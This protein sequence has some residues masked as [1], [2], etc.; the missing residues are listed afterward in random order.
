MVLLLKKLHR[1]W[2]FIAVLLVFI[3]FFPYLY[4]L[5]LEP[6][7]NYAAIA[8][9][10]RWI[11]ISGSALAGVFFKVTYE[12]Q[13][14]WDRSMVLCPNHTSVLDITALTYL[15]P[16][17]F[18]FIGKASL[19]KNPVTRIF[20]K[21]IDI[22]VTRRSK[23]SSFKAFQRANELVQQGRSVVIFPEGKI[24]DGFP[25]Q[26]HAFK[27]GA[28]RIAIQNDVPIV[29]IIIENAWDIF[30]DDG[31][32]RGS[33]P[34]IVNVHVFSPI[35]TKDFDDNNAS[36]LEKI[37]YDKMHS[38]WIMKNKSYFQKPENVQ[39]ICQERY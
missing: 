32:E 24:D 10:R 4:F 8:R 30:F 14:S 26:L 20:F 18:S 29:P 38:Y 33:R 27:S 16:I 12:S 3:L 23:V 17:P 11:S 13:F 22:P 31:A 19:L 28:F 34:G 1:Y 35:E 36:E 6:K 15:C 21:T 5:A 7:K 9:M 39:K 25:P 2:Y 37:V